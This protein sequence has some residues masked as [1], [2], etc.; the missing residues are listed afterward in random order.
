MPTAQY[1]IFEDQGVS[2]RLKFF[3]DDNDGRYLGVSPRPFP[4]ACQVLFSAARL[5]NCASML[6]PMTPMP[7]VSAAQP[8]LNFRQ[9]EPSARFRKELLDW[10]VVGAKS[11]L[12]S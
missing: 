8:N 1:C 9:Q 6:A 4:Q 7:S 2:K 3:V 10:I 5:C 12:N 11:R